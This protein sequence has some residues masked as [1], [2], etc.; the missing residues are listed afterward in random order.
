M[1]MKTN[2]LTKGHLDRQGLATTQIL[3]CAK[4]GPSN[5]DEIA[6]ER[7][8]SNYVMCVQNFKGEMEQA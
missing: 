8:V 7:M 1:K 3:G 5:L 2:S 4:G 6:A